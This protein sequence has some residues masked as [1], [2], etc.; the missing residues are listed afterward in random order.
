MASLLRPGTQESQLASYI[1]QDIK[2]R[3]LWPGLTCIFNSFKSR[4][5]LSRFKSFFAFVTSGRTDLARCETSRSSHRIRLSWV[6]STTY[7]R[8]NQWFDWPTDHPACVPVCLPAYKCIR[9]LKFSASLS[10]SLS[11][12]SFLASQFVYF[13]PSVLFLIWCFLFLIAPRLSN[14]SLDRGWISF[15]IL[16][17]YNYI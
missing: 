17:I 15:N 14:P 6:S 16:Y 4:S 10:L 1:N 8:Q 3:C 9:L 2:D 11:L 12:C 7:H 5:R 13:C